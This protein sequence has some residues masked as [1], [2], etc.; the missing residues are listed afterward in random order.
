MNWV[1]KVYFPKPHIIRGLENPL[2]IGKRCLAQ[3]MLQSMF[4]GHGFQKYLQFFCYCDSQGVKVPKINLEF[5][6]RKRGSPSETAYQVFK[7]CRP[8]HIP[9]PFAWMVLFSKYAWCR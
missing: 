1:E 7:R 3:N 8:F 6:S 4:E 5:F 2:S 9:E